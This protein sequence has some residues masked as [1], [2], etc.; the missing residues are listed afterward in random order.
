MDK[1]VITKKLNQISYLLTIPEIED[2]GLDEVNKEIWG[3]INEIRN[4]LD[5]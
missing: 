5:K 3:L 4:E 2:E 1:E